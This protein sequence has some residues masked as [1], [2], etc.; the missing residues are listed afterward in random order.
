MVPRI[1]T[2]S[3]LVILLYQKFQHPQNTVSREIMVLSSKENLKCF[4]EGKCHPVVLG[5]NYPD[6]LDHGIIL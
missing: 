6:F 1:I 3:L 5:G 2:R 4:W